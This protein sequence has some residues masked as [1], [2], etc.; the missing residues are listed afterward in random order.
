M[1]TLAAVL[2]LIYLSS[3]VLWDEFTRR[4]TFVLESQPSALVAAVF[5]YCVSNFKSLLELAA[6]LSAVTMN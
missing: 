5:L 6:C 1:D 3:F 2:A 4:W